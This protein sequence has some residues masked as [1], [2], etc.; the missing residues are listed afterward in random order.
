MWSGGGG[1]YDPEGLLSTVPAIASTLAG[2]FAG[3]FLRSAHRGSSDAGEAARTATS[4]TVAG[5]RM[6]MAGLALVLAGLVWDRF[7]PINKPLWTSSYVAYTTGWAMVTLAALYWLIDVPGRRRWA[8]PA[9]LARCPVGHVRAP[10]LHQDLAARGTAP[11]P[12]EKR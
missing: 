4:G 6:L 1:V 12:W 3:D 11:S 7:F 8:L 5:L 2:L 9:L 10:D